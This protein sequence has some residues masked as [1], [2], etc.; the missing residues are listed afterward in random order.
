MDEIWISHDISFRPEESVHG[1][2]IMAPAE[3]IEAF[4]TGRQSAHDPEKIAGALMCIQGVLVCCFRGLALQRS[5]GRYLGD[6]HPVSGF[7]VPGH[8]KPV[9]TIETVPR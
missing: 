2:G 9:A 4:M 7:N 5:P 8:C 1:Y 3:E 6:L